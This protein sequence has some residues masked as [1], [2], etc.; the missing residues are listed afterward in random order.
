MQEINLDAEACVCVHVHVCAPACVRACLHACL[1]VRASEAQCLLCVTR[2]LGKVR[3]GSPVLNEAPLL[4]A[5]PPPFVQQSGTE[6]TCPDYRDSITPD[7]PPPKPPTLQRPPS[8]GTAAQTISQ[9]TR[10][11]VRCA[12]GL[13]K[14]A[15]QCT[16][17][18]QVCSVA[19]PHTHKHTHN[20]SME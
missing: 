6:A 20:I 2:L 14:C 12:V 10:D 8:I 5:S 7:I 1:C 17:C 4:L 3:A 11:L 16:T 13:L 15:L 18:K 9:V 19:R